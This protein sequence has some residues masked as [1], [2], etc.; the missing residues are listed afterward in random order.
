MKNCI[1]ENILVTFTDGER[2]STHCEEYVR[3]AQ[4]DE[5]PMLFVSNNLA[6]YQSEIEGIEIL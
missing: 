1:G 3:K 5:E 2:L 6:L 4:E